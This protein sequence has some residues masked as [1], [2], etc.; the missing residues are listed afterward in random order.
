MRESYINLF[1]EYMFYITLK[2]CFLEPKFLF[3]SQ[4]LLFVPCHLSSLARTANSF[5]RSMAF[6]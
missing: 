2:E 5:T 3:L 6:R 4:R 1:G